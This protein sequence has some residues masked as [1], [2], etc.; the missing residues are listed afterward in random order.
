MP[1]LGRWINRDPIEERGGE[2]MYFFVKNKSDVFFDNQGLAYDSCIYLPNI[3]KKV[4]FGKTVRKF[5]LIVF[6]LKLRI[7]VKRIY[8]FS[9]LLCSQM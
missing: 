5:N 7:V 4:K 6:D 9:L 1:E 3:S 8:F 2:N